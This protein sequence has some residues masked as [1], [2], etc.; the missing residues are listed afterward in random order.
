[1]LLQVYTSN[2]IAGGH[3]ALDTINKMII[4]VVGSNNNGE[5]VQ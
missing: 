3:H 5:L 4:R 2:F 1:M